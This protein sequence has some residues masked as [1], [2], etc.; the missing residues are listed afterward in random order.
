MES[1]RP[2]GPRNSRGCVT[3]MPGVRRAG[4][5]PGRARSAGRRWLLLLAHGAGL[6][7][8]PAAA[9]AQR[10]AED[11]RV[12]ALAAISIFGTAAADERLR[13]ALHGPGPPAARAVAHAVEPLG[14]S[15]NALAGIAA[16]YAAARLSRHPAWARA[17]LHVAGGYLAADAVEATLKAVVDRARPEAELGPYA[18]HA[19]AAGEHHHSFP[20]GHTTH[21]F[22]LAAGISHE[23]DRPWVTVATYGTAA[24]VGW[25]RVHDDA[26]WSSDVVAGSLVGTSV[27]LAA[28]RWQERRERRRAGARPPPGDAG[29]PDTTAA[30]WHVVVVPGGVAASITF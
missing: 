7:G 15:R 23:A 11:E 2:T 30:R 4:R 25:S 20:S 18:F 21:A 6:L 8:A 1:C 16:S 17:T 5:S 14:R 28:I 22:A 9:A 26:H 10:R 24:L 27:S 3:A 19:R 29:G 12:L 13:D